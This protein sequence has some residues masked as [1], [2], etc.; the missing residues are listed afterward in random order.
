M[1]DLSRPEPDLTLGE[2]DSLAGSDGPVWAA[3]RYS[4]IT[5]TA[6]ALIAAGLYGA[7]I[8]AARAASQAGMP[9]AE[10]IFYRALILVPLLA[11][12]AFALQQPLRLGRAERGTMIRLAISAG[13]TA[14]FYLSALD[15]LSVPL[16]VVI[17]YIFPLFVM[18]ISN[19]LEGRRLSGK[20]IGI[21]ALAF[22]GLVIAVGPSFAELTVKGVVFALIASCACAALFILAGRVQGPPIRTM[23][24]IQLGQGPIA[25]TFTLLNGGPVPLST[26]ANAP[27]AISIAMGAYAVAFIFQLVASQRISASRA[28]LL[29][30]FEPVTAI[31]IAGLFIGE[32]LAPV[33]IFGVAL[34]L[35]ALAAEVV[36]DTPRPAIPATPDAET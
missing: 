34:I 28:G 27:V 26:F 20:Q 16:T 36:L 18:L 23:F 14:T 24:W 30:L 35:A 29:F 12:V 8:P 21:F 19:R 2:P 5:G 17:F 13:L 32:T 9:G 1:N 6:F 15:H 31:V 33:Q 22:A 7:N 3:A 11:A 25:L 10:L 4:L